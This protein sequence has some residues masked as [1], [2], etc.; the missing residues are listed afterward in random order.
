[1]P[2]KTRRAP[3]PPDPFRALPGETSAAVYLRLHCK[4]LAEGIKVIVEG[5][6]RYA[7][8]PTNGAK[9]EFVIITLPD[10]EEET[11]C[12]C[13]RAGNMTGAPCKHITLFHKPTA[14]KD[15]CPMCS[16]QLL[17]WHDPNGHAVRCRNCHYCESWQDQPVKQDPN[18]AYHELYGRERVA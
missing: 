4:A 1:M 18:V 17:Y 9:Y 16:G 13:P 5:K 6:K 12:S 3:K 10:G 14:V 15:P 11:L 2:A 8:N 7:H